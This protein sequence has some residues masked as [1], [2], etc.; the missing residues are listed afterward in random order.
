MKRVGV[1]SFA[2]LLAACPGH[3]ATTTSSPPPFPSS[4]FPTTTPATTASSSPS[5][6]AKASGSSAPISKNPILACKTTWPVKDAEDYTFGSTISAD[7]RW[8][9]LYQIVIELP[10]AKDQSAALV[11]YL[12]NRAHHCVVTL[13]HP[14]QHAH[15][16]ASLSGHGELISF[17]DNR[18]L[19]PADTNK[20]N[21]VY[22][23]DLHTARLT[24]ASVALGGRAGN[25]LSVDRDLSADASTV[26]FG[27]RAT[28]LTRFGDATCTEQGDRLP[29]QQLYMRDLAAKK[30]ILIT[31][32][33]DG[34]A[35]HGNVGGAAVSANGQ[36]V[37]FDSDASDLVPGDTNGKRDVFL[38][39]RRTGTI[40][41]ISVSSTGAQIEED[42]TAP[43]ISDDGTFATF[44]SSSTVLDPSGDSCWDYDDSGATHPCTDVFL[45]D[46]S[47][48]KMSLLQ[49]PE[50]AGY[51]V[52][53]A[54][55]GPL[56]ADG[57]YVLVRSAYGCP[58]TGCS[59]SNYR[60]DVTTHTFKHI[61][62]GARSE[63][64]DASG[65][66]ILARDVNDTSICC[67]HCW[68]A[69]TGKSE[70]CSPHP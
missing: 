37:V 17:G 29:C 15:E 57:H 3:R 28:N 9:A 51:G 67:T 33:I 25:G 6:S 14:N 27:S 47:T 44:T 66:F 26:V 62:W 12:W 56:S 55:G 18:A 1:L 65:H 42:A 43:H 49:P 5:A 64:M 39:D 30:T 45:R 40:K 52:Q 59:F 22:V 11:L 54:S 50:T 8:V 46:L 19:L 48:G 34:G 58:Y 31:R 41:R 70:F 38:Y 69:T 63:D 60:Y 16:G 21:D 35:S 32:N 2:L 61:G 24:L 7:G 10:P 36:K 53:D 4:I 23:M 68:D 20:L 13:K